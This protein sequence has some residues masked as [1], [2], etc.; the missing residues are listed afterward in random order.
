LS[1]KLGDEQG[2][3]LNSIISYANLKRKKEEIDAD[4]HS[5]IST[6]FEDI[7]VRLKEECD[8]LNKQA[9]IN[10]FICFFLALILIGYITYSSLSPIESKGYN[11]IQLFLMKYLPRIVSIVSLLTMFLYFTRL[12]KSNILDVKYYQNELT[13]IELK[14]VSLKTGLINGD[15]DVLN[16][17]IKKYSNTERNYIITKEQTTGELER[18]KIENEINK[19]YLNKVWEMLSLIRKDKS[20]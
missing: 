8:R 11:N 19:D 6:I 2:P 3:F 12:Y 17:L 5:K 4:K 15:K 18:I 9:L 14:L 16:Y 13:N 10:L 20:N 1:L 7:Q